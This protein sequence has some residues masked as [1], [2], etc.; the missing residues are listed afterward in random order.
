MTKFSLNR[1]LTRRQALKV[2]ISAV[3][4][5]AILS[6][7][8]IKV[9]SYLI[10]TLAKQQKEKSN[11]KRTFKVV[12]KNS[13]KKRAKAKGLIY[14]AFPQADHP[15]FESTPKL[16]AS[17]VKECDLM[18]VGLFWD[19]INPKVD[20]FNFTGIDYFTK[21]A[22]KNKMLLRGVPL[23]WHLSLP[24]WLLETIN[25]QNAEQIMTK[26]IETVVRRYRGKFHSWDVVN[27]AIDLRDGHPDGLRN[28]PWLKSMGPDYI[29]K[30]FRV[31]ARS[32]PKALLVY[33][34]TGLEYNEA[35]Q[36]AVFNLLKQLKRKGT[37]IHALGIQSHLEGDRYDFNPQKFR[38]FIRNVASLGLKIIITELDVLDNNLPL[39]A[40]KRDLIVATVYED[41]LTAVLAEKSVIAIVNWGLSDLHTWVT[42]FYPRK[43]RFPAR[44]LPFDRNFKPKLAWNAIARAIDRAPNR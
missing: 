14:G 26:H 28:T 25:P 23:V 15:S 44:P 5:L 13:L 41:Y 7:A 6:F 27:E 36:T 30:A 9:L 24:H 4:F 20:T 29:E 38:K 33:N 10:H 18:A 3:T 39:D 31:A 8:K 43:D 42:E 16:K 19:Q 2:G 32:D 22:A 34:E 37:P 12:G 1:L 40:N 21:F 35:H 11:Q 17:F